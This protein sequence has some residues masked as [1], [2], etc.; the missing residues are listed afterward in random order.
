M[1]RAYRSL[2]LPIHRAILN[3]LHLRFPTGLTHHSPQN[4]GVKGPDIARAV[5]LSKS[6]GMVPGW[7]D[8]ITIADGKVMAWEVKSE[9]GTASDAQ[10][11]V[12][13]MLI[14]NGARWAVVRSID[15][16]QQCL[17]EWGVP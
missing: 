8:L 2:E 16:V 1:T 12:G 14:A 15:D 17:A 9:G 6:M 10:K 13:A 4:L 3:Y 11:N 7:P 5:S